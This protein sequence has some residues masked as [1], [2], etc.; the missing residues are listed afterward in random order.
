MKEAEG[1]RRDWTLEDF[2]KSTETARFQI[3]GA[4]FV[5]CANQPALEEAKWVLRL[6]DAAGSPILGL[7]ANICVQK[8]AAEVVRFLDLLRDADGSLPKGLK[9]AR[10]VF[11]M[12][13]NQADDACLDAQFLEGLDALGK[14]GLLWEFCCEPRMAPFLCGCIERFPHMTFVIDHLAHNGNKGGD[15]EA[16]GP[17]MDS[18]GKLPNVYVKLGATEEWDVPN[19]EDFLDRA[20]QAIGF[21][22]V[23]YESNWFVNEA[24]GDQYDRS[25]GLVYDACKRAGASETDLSKVFHDNACKV[26]LG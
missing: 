19:P 20:I 11:M 21:D 5:E 6:M 4:I 12:W 2:R 23:L 24:M 25:A 14:A 18:L 15:M 7:V 3:S 16:W 17:A 9:G 22:R 1:F 8:G 26:L 10:Y 13:E